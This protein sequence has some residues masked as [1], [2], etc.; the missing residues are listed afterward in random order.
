MKNELL[1]ITSKNLQEVVSKIPE[2]LLLADVDQLKKEVQ[3]TKK[4]RELKISVQNELMRARLEGRTAAVSRMCEGVI[5]ESYFRDKIMD[6]KELMAWLLLPDVNSDLK[7][8]RIYQDSL[9]DVDEMMSN[10]MIEIENEPDTNMRIKLRDQ[11]YKFFSTFANRVAPI[12]QRQEIKTQTI[13]FDSVAEPRSVEER[14]AE[15]E[16]KNRQG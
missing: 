12:V 7:M 3:P 1:Q 4:Q 9:G 8:K 15:L 16:E 14:I 5:S 6:K 2:E 13:P 10:L 11:Y